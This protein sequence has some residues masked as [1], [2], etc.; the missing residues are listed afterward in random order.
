[1]DNKKTIF[2]SMMYIHRMYDEPITIMDISKQAYL[3]PTYFSSLFRIFTG[4]T[5]KNYLNRYRL[6]RAAL[7]LKN[8]NKRI[9]DIAISNGFSSHQ[10]FTRSFSQT[11]YVSP[12]QFR[13]FNTTLD[14]FPPKYLMEEPI[15]TMEL[16]ECLSFDEI[17]V[18]TLLQN[19]ISK[20]GSGKQEK[21]KGDNNELNSKHVQQIRGIIAKNATCRRLIKSSLP[22]IVEYMRNE[23]YKDTHKV[24]DEAF[25]NV[26]AYELAKDEAQM[27]VYDWDYWDEFE[28]FSIAEIR[29]VILD[30]EIYKQRNISNE[31]LQTERNQSNKRAALNKIIDQL[32]IVND[33][34]WFNRGNL[35]SE[36]AFEIAYGNLIAMIDMFNLL[37]ND[38]K[39]LAIEYD[40]EDEAWELLY[41]FI[42]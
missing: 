37:Q 34:R 30:Y 24:D 2:D 36:E 32:N 26:K 18:S 6:Y 11:Y 3:S 29:E 38:T 19:T 5:V 23:R 25:I 16:M 31:I 21:A 41:D 12:A 13:L 40:E 20:G 4:Y 35:F 7:E 1:M 42:S 9:I 33:P 14:P 10:A 27:I 17:M 39:N 28:S 22:G 8:S 15:L